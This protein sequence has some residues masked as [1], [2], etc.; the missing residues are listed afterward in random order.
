MQAT[1]ENGFLVLTKE[2]FYEAML[3]KTRECRNLS[4]KVGVSK[5]DFDSKRNKGDY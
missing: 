3:L 1:A 4:L 5:L 2:E